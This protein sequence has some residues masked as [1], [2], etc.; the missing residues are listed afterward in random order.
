MRVVT[1]AIALA[2]LHSFLLIPAEAKP[3]Q[4]RPIII[5]SDA[6]EADDFPAR[7]GL[8]SVAQAGTT[9]IGWSPTGGGPY[10][11]G[12]PGLW[13]FEDGGTVPC[14]PQNGWSEYIKNGAYAQHWT[15]ED[16]YAQKGLYWHAEDF[17]NPGFACSGNPITGVYSAWCGIVTPNPGE[18]FVDSPGYGPD[19]N[20]WLKRSVILNSTNP[21]LIFQ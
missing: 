20:Q 6:G 19:W 3:P 12:A 2:T 14:P 11:I 16:V 18:C 17:T 5:D 13:D 4:E 10:G 1:L 21:K 7:S 8:F 9:W 15:S